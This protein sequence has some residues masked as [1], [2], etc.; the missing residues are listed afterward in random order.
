MGPNENLIHSFVSI[1]TWLL[2]TVPYQLCPSS[3]QQFILFHQSETNNTQGRAQFRSHYLILTHCWLCC[4]NSKCIRMTLCQMRHGATDTTIWLMHV[5]QKCYGTLQ[6]TM[7]RQILP[8]HT[9]TPNILVT[10][11]MNQIRYMRYTTKCGK[12][13]LSDPYAKYYSPVKYSAELIVLFRG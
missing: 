11:K 7:M 2:P 1:W 12:D 4:F 8:Y 9:Q 6:N 5:Y 3:A 10:T 13:K